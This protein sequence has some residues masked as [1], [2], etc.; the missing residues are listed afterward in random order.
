[1]PSVG[2]WL[3]DEWRSAHR[4]EP[5]LWPDA[6]T[7]QKLK[8]YAVGEGTSHEPA[9]A[10]ASRVSFEPTHVILAPHL[11]A[12]GADKRIVDYA[13]AVVE[14][15]GKPLVILTDRS[16]DGSWQDKTP[17]GVH[18]VDASQPLELAAGGAKLALA[19]LVARWRPGVVHVVNSQRGYAMIAR[20]GAAVA[21]SCGRVYASIYGAEESGGMLGG[22]AFNGMFFPARAHVA[23]MLSDNEAMLALLAEVHGWRDA[24]VV[25]SVVETLDEP[26]YEALL[27]ERAAGPKGLVRV[28]WASRMERCKRLDRLKAVADLA[29]ARRLPVGFAVAGQPCDARSRKWAESLRGMPN[30]KL[31]L[32]RFDGW[33]ALLPGKHDVYMCTSESEGM[34]NTL[35]EAAARGLAIVSS[36]VGD[37]GRVPGARVVEDPDDPAQWL[38]AVVEHAASRR[39]ETLDYVARRH[40]KEA[41]ATALG[42]A[43]YFDFLKE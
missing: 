21:S 23:R 12:G 13:T 37:V 29:L 1:V 27:R 34:P 43:G 2:P 17:E 25:P 4:I 28:L 11:S 39:Q 7:A 3:Y 41:F 42:G 18:V 31:S 24:T 9:L 16:S 36:H 14:R 33:S 38:S 40:S 26:S 19:R 35:L 8:R 5:E 32:G 20:Y 22:A 10:I 15:G 30:V 6:R